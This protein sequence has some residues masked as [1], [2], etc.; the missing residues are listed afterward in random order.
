MPNSA[1]IEDNTIIQG[2]DT[3]GNGTG[4]Y[5]ALDATGAIT[6]NV[7]DSFLE[8]ALSGLYSGRTA[9]EFPIFGRRN[10]GWNS[11]SAFGDVVQYLDTS[12]NDINAVAT[13]TTYYVRSSS[14]SDTL[15]GTG[16]QK[17]NITSLNASGV[18]QTA[19]YSLNGTTG[20]S[21]GSGYSYFEFMEVSA[22]G[23]GGVSAGNITIGSV[24][25]APT[26]AQTVE[27]I[28]AGG[29]RSLS[30]RFMVPSGYQGCIIDWDA[31]GVG[32]A[33]YDV[34]LR[35]K[36]NAYN[37]S[38]STV[39]HFQGTFYLQQGVYSHED[40]HMRLFP[41]LCEIKISCIPSNAAAANKLDAG[42]DILL[43][44]IA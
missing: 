4:N 17:V 31:S 40:M 28:V 26:V 2:A 8:L 11:T 21:L 36:V 19:E 6:A 37:R 20:V 16:A 13:G 29:N 39:F 15:A 38:L 34:R 14:A 43:V 18:L 42:F 25:G 1:L 41:A 3:S 30:G 24:N 5:L 7:K 27:Y 35:A 32:G 44:A 33:D 23:S 10:A 9:L 22:V 12:Q